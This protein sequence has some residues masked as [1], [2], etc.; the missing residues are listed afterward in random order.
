MNLREPAPSRRARAGRLSIAGMLAAGTLALLAACGG[1]G[2]DSGPPIT[3]SVLSSTSPDWV[4][5]GDAAI[6][7][8]GNIPAGT[9]LKVALNGTDV[10]SSFVPDPA[11]GRQ[12]GVVNGMT[13]RQEHPDRAARRRLQCDAGRHPRWC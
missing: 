12:V 2:G 8:N 7:V 6:A 10:T 3:V 1:G 11:G 13:E 4:S 9:T 5:G